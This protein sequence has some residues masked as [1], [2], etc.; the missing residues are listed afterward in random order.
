[1]T[2][3][4][5]Y[6]EE[7]GRVGSLCFLDGDQRPQRGHPV[8]PRGLGLPLWGANLRALAVVAFQVQTWG[9]LKPA[10]ALE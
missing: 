1:M 4:P 6:T 2:H 10:G 9:L 8:L 7:K 5:V 3:V